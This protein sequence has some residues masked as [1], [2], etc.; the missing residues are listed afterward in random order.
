MKTLQP[1]TPS[2]LDQETVC[3]P[4]EDIVVREIEG[5]LILIPIV[6]GVGDAEGA[7][8]TFNDTGRDIWEKLDGKRTVR[9]VA[10]ELSS[11]YV[12]SIENIEMD[13]IGLV[14]ELIRRNMLVKK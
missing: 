3:A 2:P 5:E 12:T 8:F 6:A 10:Q 9:Q 1:I 14:S 11:K 13:V 7:I 4:S